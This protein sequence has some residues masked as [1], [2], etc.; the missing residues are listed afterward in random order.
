MENNKCSNFWWCLFLFSCNRINRVINVGIAVAFLLGVE[1]Y[2]DLCS[3]S[4][5][6]YFCVLGLYVF[7]ARFF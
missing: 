4:G 6:I 2:T 1:Q 3:F 7:V 5:C